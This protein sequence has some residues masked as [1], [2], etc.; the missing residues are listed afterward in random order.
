[1]RFVK[2]AV[3][4]LKVFVAAW[5]VNTVGWYAFCFVRNYYHFSLTSPLSWQSAADDM[6]PLAFAE[7]AVVP[8][9]LYFERQEKAAQEPKQ[10]EE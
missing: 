3:L 8:L 2:V 9:K 6:L 1:M 4:C 7:A 5:A 10:A